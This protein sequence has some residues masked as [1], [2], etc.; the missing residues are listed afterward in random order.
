MEI[1]DIYGKKSTTDCLGCSI[2][3]GE[4]TPPGGFILKTDHFCVNQDCEIPI[5]GFFI[6]S[7]IRHIQS[8]DE[9]YEPEQTDFM[10]IL[11]KMRQG[12]RE[13]LNI[14]QIDIIMVEN[15]EHHF[16]VWLFPITDEMTEKFGF[17]VKALKP[18]MSYAIENMKT[19]ENI[20][21]VE[22]Y[23]GLIKT[24]LSK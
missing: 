15:G 11:V 8:F 2:A 19:A 9:F 23:I 20:K 3:E 5:P 14:P 21:K 17:G 4:F 18:M 6:I 12:M 22:K 13:A 1:I 24:H 10:Q 7:S 16:H